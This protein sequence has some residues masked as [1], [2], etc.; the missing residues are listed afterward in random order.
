MASHRMTLTRLIVA[1]VCA[2][3][4]GA[5]ATSNHYESLTVVSA[6]DVRHA[7]AQTPAIPPRLGIAFGGGG[8]RGFMH[9]GVLQALDEAGIR[10]DVVT[11]T[12][13]GAIAA[14]LYAS[15][16]PY[17]QIEHATLSVSELELADLVISREGF[18]QGR[19]LA[20][21]LNQVTGHR[22]IKSLPVPLG[23]TVTDLAEGEA[24]LVV[25]GDVGQA[26][27]ASASVPGAVIPVRHKGITYVDGGI[28][29]L[30]PVRF[31]RSLGAEVVI[32]IDIYC[33]NKAALKGNALDNLLRA[34]RL[35]SCA[36]SQVEAAEADF[37]IR[38]SF[39]PS[40]YSSFDQREEA[41]KAGYLAAKVIMPALQERLK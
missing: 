31:A 5:C 23:V 11:G 38:P 21:W 29:S 15:G 18:F 27:Q 36:L 17:Q 33:G 40:S 6:K 26:V 12:S 16:M 25:D 2:I 4:L 10:A 32:A 7:A 13:S 3:L 14:A 1:A 19:A 41:I 20:S 22:Q 8:V 34:L 37:L 9:L 39:E 30:V 24:L 35:Q 28:L